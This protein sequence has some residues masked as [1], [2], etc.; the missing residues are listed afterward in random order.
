MYYNPDLVAEPPTSIEELT[1]A[2]DELPADVEC[3]VVPGGNDGG[4]AYHHQPFI[5]AEGGQLFGFDEA[6]GFDGSEVLIGSDETVAGATLLEQLVSDGYVPSTNYGDAKNL[7]VTG[8]AAFWF[9]GPWEIGSLNNPEEN[10]G[11]PNWSVALMPTADGNPMRPHVGIQA[12][13]LSAYAKN[14]AIATEFLLN[15]IATPETM[16]ALY[17]A[18]PRG[19]A[20]VATIDEIAG[21]PV[22]AVFAA[23]VATGTYMPNIPEM[24]SVWGPVGDN[25]LLLRNGEIDAATAMATAQEQVVAAIE[26]G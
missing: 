24:G 13:Y 10:T 23:S 18:D 26:G 17:E 21:D 6:T 5:T 1:A 7:F 22:A 16:T 12:F 25:F 19:S 20:Y 8:K 9:T 15:F 4:D 2:C 3:L 11:A 14:P